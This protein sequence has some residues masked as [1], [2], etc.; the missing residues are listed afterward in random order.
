MK[1]NDIESV[2]NYVSKYSSYKDEFDA[3]HYVDLYVNRVGAWTVIISNDDGEGNY[4][5]YVING[6]GYSLMDEERFTEYYGRNQAK[7]TFV[8]YVSEY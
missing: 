3:I 7:D 4:Y 1:M 6:I 5:Y 2:M 8:K